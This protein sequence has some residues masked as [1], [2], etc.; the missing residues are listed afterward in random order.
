[1]D[2]VCSPLSHEHCRENP[3]VDE[4]I[5]WEAG[6]CVFVCAHAYEVKNDT[7]NRKLF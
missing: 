7:I 1:V 5:G 2:A 4:R 3:A 6:V